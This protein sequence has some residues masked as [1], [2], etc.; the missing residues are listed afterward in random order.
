MGGENEEEK[1]L[2]DIGEEL[3]EAQLVQ[4]HRYVVQSFL[5]SRSLVN[6][7]SAIASE[8][9]FFVFL[10]SVWAPGVISGVVDPSP[11]LC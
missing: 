1:A 3:L 11:F 8:V 7:L 5:S 2:V 6:A 10:S 9:C 4:A